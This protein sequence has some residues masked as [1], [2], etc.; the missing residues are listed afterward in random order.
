M[1]GGCKHR[2]CACRPQVTGLKMHLATSTLPE[3][4]GALLSARL[5]WGQQRPRAYSS[6]LPCLPASAALHVTQPCMSPSLSAALC[7]LCTF[8]CRRANTRQVSSSHGDRAVPW[9][10]M[11]AAQPTRMR[12]KPIPE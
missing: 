10:W 2:E 5:V 4:A 1:P 11:L 12:G 7:E 9:Q 6:V 3:S 8:L